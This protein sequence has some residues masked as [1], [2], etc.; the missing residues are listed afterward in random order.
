MLFINFVIQYVFRSRF[1][2]HFIVVH[3]YKG[4]LTS[5]TYYGM[6]ETKTDSSRVL[7][8][9]GGHTACNQEKIVVFIFFTVDEQIINS[10]ES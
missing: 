10:N 3:P 2:V 1:L 6:L 9:N 5:S 7:V 8:C 4:L